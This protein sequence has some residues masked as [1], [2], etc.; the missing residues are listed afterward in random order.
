MRYVVRRNNGEWMYP[1]R[2]TKV[3]YES[4]TAWGNDLEQARVFNTKSAATTAA[5]ATDPTEKW[6]LCQVKLV[7][8][9]DEKA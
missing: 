4:R 5:R 6:K 2:A 3:V 8:F 7:V 9:Q 1:R